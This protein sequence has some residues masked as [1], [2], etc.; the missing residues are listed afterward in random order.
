MA[1]KRIVLSHHAQRRLT[2][3]RQDGVTEF[4]VYA[5]CHKA[6][7]I[8]VKGVPLNLKLGGFQSKEGV[9][10]DIIVVDES[11]GILLIVS[12]IGHMY[13]RKRKHHRQDAYRMHHLP[14][15]E[16]VKLLRKLRKQE[17]KW[18]PRVSPY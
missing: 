6:S 13:A 15:K 3:R 12:V 2:E 14:Y 17:R 9:R 4:D 1:Q 18:D 11:P 10:F 16:Q 7:E 5:A 8:L